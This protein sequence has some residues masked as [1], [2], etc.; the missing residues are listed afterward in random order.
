VRRRETLVPSQQSR[1]AEVWAVGQD[2]SAN[3]TPLYGHTQEIRTRAEIFGRLS[4]YDLHTVWWRE[5]EVQLRELL[6]R[7]GRQYDR[8]LPMASEAQQLLR[9][10][11][12]EL[13]QWVPEGYLIVGSGGKGIGAV[14]PWISVFDPDETTTAQR[15]MYVV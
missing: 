10:A 13:R 9:R 12:D 11:G 2:G 14:C 15:G 5:N 3:R 8:A 1:R 7:I 6:G 4:S